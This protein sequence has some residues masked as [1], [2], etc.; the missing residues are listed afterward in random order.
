LWRGFVK[1]L[2]RVLNYETAKSELYGGK[3]YL[4]QRP[5]RFLVDGWRSLLQDRHYVTCH[6]SKYYHLALDQDGIAFRE[7]YM[8]FGFY[9]AILYC[10]HLLR[11]AAS[12]NRH[13][14]R[15]VPLYAAVLVLRSMSGL[16]RTVSRGAAAALAFIS[17]AS[18][19][20]PKN[21]SCVDGGIPCLVVGAE[22]SKRRG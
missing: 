20:F 17:G 6:V 1:K 2:D 21:I 8:S 11:L 5:K 15:R 16:G 18:A 22:I 4:T 14:V 13:T 3:N 12:W 10:H 19:D 7:G 9:Q